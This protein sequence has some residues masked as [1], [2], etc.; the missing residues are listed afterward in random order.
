MNL[1]LDTHALI[2]WREG[3]KKLG[4]RAR[5]VIERS[6]AEVRISAATAWEIAVKFQAGRLSL[7]APVELWLPAALD[8]S[9]FRRLDISVAH[10][11]TAGTLPEHHTDPFDRLL[12]AQAQLETLTIVTSDMAFDAYDVKVLDARR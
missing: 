4:R 2:W 3:N 11:L 12:I 7:S 10:A 6:A 5:A 1:L 9:G 8:H